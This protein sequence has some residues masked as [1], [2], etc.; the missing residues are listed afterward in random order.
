M[1]HSR[2]GLFFSNYEYNFSNLRN[3][4]IEQALTEAARKI[5][6]Q[7]ASNPDLANQALDGKWVYLLEEHEYLLELFPDIPKMT[8]PPKMPGGHGGTF[9]YNMTP[10]KPFGLIFS[11][12]DYLSTFDN[13]VI[14][15]TIAEAT[16]QIYQEL[17]PDPTLANQTVNQEWGY[18]HPIQDTD[19]S[20]W[21]DIM[22]NG[23]VMTYGDIPVLLG[24]L[25]T[26]ATD[27][28]TV[29]TDFAIFIHPGTE[30]QRQVGQGFL[31][32]VF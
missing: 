28:R 9:S 20:Y 30:Q 25:E 32:F 12:Y 5:N 29:E 18:S 2:L 11:Q 7:L 4:I 3:T 15:Q 23:P 17:A 24:V 8:K 31:L 14:E 27:Y 22:P 13:D 26:W 19:D 10:D 1:T 16:H 6:D 21:L